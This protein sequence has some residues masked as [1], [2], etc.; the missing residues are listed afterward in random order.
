[1]NIGLKIKEVADKKNISAKDLADRIGRTRQAVYDIYS[2]KV[3]INVTLLE[4]IC[5]ALGI[6]VYSL[7]TTENTLPKSKEELKELIGT[8]LGEVI[9]KNY[10][11]LTTVKS[12]VMR[13]LYKAHGGDGIVSLGLAK[14]KET[15]MYVFSEEYRPL[16]SKLSDKELAEFGKQYFGNFFGGIK[17]QLDYSEYSKIIS[18]YIDR[19]FGSN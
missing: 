3:S 5:N 17:E 7:F 19:K 16:K 2:G 8:V 18:G 11:D 1:M 4:S 13:L 9:K 10:V 15:G 12:L 6:E 14:D